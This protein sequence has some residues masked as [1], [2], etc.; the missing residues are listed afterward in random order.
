[1][2][3]NSVE[4]GNN[5]VFVPSHLQPPTGSVP[6]S[7]QTQTLTISPIP[8]DSQKKAEDT[9]KMV[10]NPTVASE[11]AK[12]KVGRPKKSLLMN[13]PN[14][15]NNGNNNEKLVML[16]QEST[17]KVGS[18]ENKE[19]KVMIYCV[20]SGRFLGFVEINVSSFLYALRDT[21]FSDGVLDGDLLEK[22]KFLYRHAP[23]SANQEKRIKIEDCLKEIS[24]NRTIEVTFSRDVKTQSPP[25]V[26]SPS[27]VT[28][29][30]PQPQPPQ[31]E[32]DYLFNMQ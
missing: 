6:N 2:E 25:S 19:E 15:N 23:V 11:K 10:A 22:M 13:D 30:A 16:V 29:P 26:S 9:A 3:F 14:N 27:S 18:E 24:S 12:K 21:I 17:T 8:N 5:F 1:V 32:V 20:E 31:G 4:K 28:A 7:V